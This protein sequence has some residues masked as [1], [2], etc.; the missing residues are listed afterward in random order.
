[1][2]SS[3]VWGRG[4]AFGLLFCLASALSM[5]YIERREVDGVIT[6]FNSKSVY[7]GYDIGACQSVTATLRAAGIRYKLKSRNRLGGWGS[8]TRGRVGAYGM[9]PDYMYEYEVL[10][11]HRDYEQAVYEIRKV[12]H[13]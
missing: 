2:G 7:L 11:H 1:M 12:S 4:G 9:N 8:V 3:P 13:R 6:I 5:C 10:V